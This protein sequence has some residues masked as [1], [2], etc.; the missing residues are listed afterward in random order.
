[1]YRQW[2]SNG[3]R[4]KVTLGELELWREQAE[5]IERSSTHLATIDGIIQSLK[6]EMKQD[7]DLVPT[8]EVDLVVYQ[9]YLRDQTKFNQLAFALIAEH[10]Q[11]QKQFLFD[12]D[13]E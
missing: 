3:N 8:C 10:N 2:I 7:N 1:M 9:T 6:Q 4:V 5:A 13:K 11:K 12:L